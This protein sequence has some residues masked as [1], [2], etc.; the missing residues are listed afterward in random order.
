MSEGLSKANYN[1]I[2][3]SRLVIPTKPESQKLKIK[4]QQEQMS[5]F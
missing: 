2:P 5:Y 3:I 4:K 1:T